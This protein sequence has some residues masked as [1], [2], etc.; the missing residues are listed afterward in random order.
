[1]SNE[2]LRQQ[3]VS[4]AL[5]QLKYWEVQNAKYDEL[6]PIIKIASKVRKTL[7]Q[8]WTNKQVQ[9]KEK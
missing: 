7:N 9:Q 1:M 8:K 2:I 4:H 5:T 3:V 6:R